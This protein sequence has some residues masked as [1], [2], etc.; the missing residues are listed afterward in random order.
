M[1]LV[2]VLSI[3]NTVFS[4]CKVPQEVDVIRFMAQST[5]LKGSMVDL[6]KIK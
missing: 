4:I 2:A 3:L 5:G 1:S 6:N